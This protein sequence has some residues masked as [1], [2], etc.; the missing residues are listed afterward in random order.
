MNAVIEQFVHPFIHEVPIS[1]AEASEFPVYENCPCCRSAGTPEPLVHLGTSE[2]DQKLTLVQC[3]E[4]ELIYYRNPPSADFITRYYQ[5]QWNQSVGENLGKPVKAVTKSSPRMANLMADLGCDPDRHSV[6]DVG[7]GNGKLMA[8]LA[9]AGFSD[10]WGTE[11]S[12]HRVAVCEA[13]FPGHI[14]AGGYDGIPADRKFD[15]IYSNHVV[16]HFHNPADG[17]ERLAEHL[18]ETGIIAI[19]VPDAWEESVPYQVLFLPHLHSFCARS[20]KLMGEQYGLS[21]LFWKGA[22]WEELTVIYYRDPGHIKPVPGRFLAFEQLPERSSGSQIDRIRAPWQS[23]QTEGS[24]AYLTLLRAEGNT[25]QR[26]KGYADLTG[27][28]RIAA[29]AFKGLDLILRKAKLDKLRLYLIGKRGYVRVRRNSEAGQ[30]PVI[31]MRGKR[32]AF[33][34]K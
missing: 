18:T 11:A 4:C 31:G 8:G 25:G 20:L 3:P 26:Q 6:L 29:I 23:N 13:R 17:L 16:E 30:I 2:W 15:V 9:A 27:L 14:F 21:C 22:R 33:F 34:V 12:P 1:E 19:T 7:C 32:A 10:L 5:E 28:R 24:T